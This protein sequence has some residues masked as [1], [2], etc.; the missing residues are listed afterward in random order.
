MERYTVDDRGLQMHSGALV[1]CKE[2]SELQGELPFWLRR[3]IQGW[4]AV[5]SLGRLSNGLYTI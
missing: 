2:N 5:M 3:I 4:C 1:S